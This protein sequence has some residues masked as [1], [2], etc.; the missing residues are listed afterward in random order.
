MKKMIEVI[1]YV[2]LMVGFVLL[3]TIAVH[4]EERKE[5]EETELRKVRM[6]CYTHTGN[7]TASGEMP[8][9]GGCAFQA[10]YMGYKAVIYE[11]DAGMP[12]KLI[13]IYNINDTG[14]GKATSKIN[15]DTGKPYGTIQLGYTVD[16]F[17]ESIADCKEFINQ[18]GDS[19]YIRLIKMEER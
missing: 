3:A 5:E 16:I 6:T 10:K 17:Q 18:H 8:S 15:P 7:P 12:G 2:L 19:C 13:G 11:N 4:A 9:E 14:Y 1:L